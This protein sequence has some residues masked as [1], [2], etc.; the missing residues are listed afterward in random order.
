MWDKIKEAF[1][2]GQKNL[3]IDNAAKQTFDLAM[4]GLIP[5]DNAIKTL[6]DHHRRATSHTVKDKIINRVRTV[7]YEKY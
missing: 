2:Q 5:K 6:L 1:K 4:Q 7:V 3:R